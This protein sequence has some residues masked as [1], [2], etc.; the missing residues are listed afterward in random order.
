MAQQGGHPKPVFLSKEISRVAL[1]DRYL[2]QCYATDSTN[3]SL[4]YQAID[5]PGWLTFNTT[6]RTLSGK[7][8]LPGQYLIKLLAINK[9]DTG[10]QIFMLTVYDKE[11]INIVCLGNSITNGTDKYNSYRRDLWKLLHHGNYNF[12]LVG[13]WNKHHMGGNVLDPDFDMDHEGHPGWTIA[14]MFQTPS[15]DSARGNIYEWL[16]EYIPDIVLIELGTNDVFQCRK[17]SD[18]ISDLAKLVSLFR[19]KNS[20]IKIAVAQI[21]P[22]G[23]QWAKKKLCGDSITYDSAIHTLNA[24]IAV[25]AKEHGSVASP[26]IVVDQYTGI[27]PSAQMYDDIHPNEEGKKIMAERWFKA[28]KRYLSKVKKTS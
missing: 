22:L 13:S 27:Q 7:A 11:T 6:D 24:A 9:R 21:P 26:V 15:W 25:F 23:D 28:I 20:H 14:Y 12:D 8:Q 4:R 10:Q 1:G 18:M 17:T 19:N 5:L 16:N 3:N 2:Y